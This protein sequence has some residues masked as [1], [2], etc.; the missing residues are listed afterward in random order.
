M[1]WICVFF[2]WCRIT[3]RFKGKL[4]SV[5]TTWSRRRSCKLLYV[6]HKWTGH[7]SLLWLVL[8]PTVQVSQSTQ[9]KMS[10]TVCKATWWVNASNGKKNKRMSEMLRSVARGLLPLSPATPLRAHWQACTVAASPAV[11]GQLPLTTA[12][13][14]SGTQ[15]HIV[16]SSPPSPASNVPFPASLPITIQPSCQ[17]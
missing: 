10:S 9:L 15:A 5:S 14:V 13:G 12:I 6:I 17:V 8:P 11:R 16:H 4:F 2:G 3:Q 1:F 7:R